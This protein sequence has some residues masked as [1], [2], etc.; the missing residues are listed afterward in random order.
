MHFVAWALYCFYFCMQHHPAGARTYWNVV[1][2]AQKLFP[3]SHQGAPPSCIIC[4]LTHTSDPSTLT[5]NVLR[6]VQQMHI[7]QSMLPSWQGGPCP[8]P[9]SDLRKRLLPQW[10]GSLHK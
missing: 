10:T 9:Q 2:L 4:V 8:N 1:Q 7:A 6:A 5:W 3:V